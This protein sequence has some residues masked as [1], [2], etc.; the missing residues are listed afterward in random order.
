M[1]MSDSASPAY[2]AAQERFDREQRAAKQKP[3]REWAPGPLSETKILE[4]RI[5]YHHCIYIYV[6]V[7]SEYLAVMVMGFK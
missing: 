6:F 5:V 1:M 2:M 7:F 4:N 3:N